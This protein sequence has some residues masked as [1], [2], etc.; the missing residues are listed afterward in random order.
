VLQRQVAQPSG[1]DGETVGI[2]HQGGKQAAGES[3]GVADRLVMTARVGLLDRSLAPDAGAFGVAKHSPGFGKPNF[4]GDG[5]DGSAD[6][7][8]RLVV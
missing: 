7:V 4:D 1:M 8:Q 3:G 5:M 6:L 2:F